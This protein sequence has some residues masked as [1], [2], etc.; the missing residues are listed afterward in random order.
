[1]IV[2]QAKSIELYGNWSYQKMATLKVHLNQGQLQIWTKHSHNFRCACGHVDEGTRP[3]QVLASA[4]T[5]S[6]PAHRESLGRY[7]IKG[8]EWL[9]WN[10]TWNRQIIVDQCLWLGLTPSNVWMWII[11][12]A[13]IVQLVGNR[14]AGTE[15]KAENDLFETSPETPV[16]FS[17]N[18]TGWHGNF[19]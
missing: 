4:L 10:F 5:L 6:Q 14:W 12:I 16:V 2:W 11:E 3:H 8:G 13:N 9:V 7:R 17:I 19:L 15:S 1:M 18:T